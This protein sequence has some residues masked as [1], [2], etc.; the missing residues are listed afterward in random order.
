MISILTRIISNTVGLYAAAFLVP[1]FSIHGE[2]KEYVIAGVMLGLLNILVK[3]LL[4]IVSFPLIILTFGLFTFVINAS[5][6]L[7]IRYLFV[8][9]SLESIGALIW[10]T[11]IVASIN[12]V[13][14]HNT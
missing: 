2:W 11:L 14:S 12:L 13:V 1:G 4:K 3:P 9:V 8:F 10:A 6:L 5:L 7:A